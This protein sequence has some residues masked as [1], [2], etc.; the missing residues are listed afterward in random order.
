MKASY[1]HNPNAVCLIN[2]L[3]EDNSRHNLRPR[4]H[5]HHQLLLLLSIKMCAWATLT[6]WW[7]NKLYRILPGSVSPTLQHSSCDKII[8]SLYNFKT[9]SIIKPNSTPAFYA[10]A[11]KICYLHAS[12]VYCSLH[13]S[14]A[15]KLHLWNRPQVS[16]T[17]NILYSKAMRE[18][19]EHN[20]L[21]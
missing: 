8:S 12:F 6:V 5:S 1:R 3:A 7:W 2:W 19:V 11:C 21:K 17:V 15:C 16:K 14:R 10:W 20:N 4:A 9:F 18:N 13:V